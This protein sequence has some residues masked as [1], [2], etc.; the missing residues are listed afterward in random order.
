MNSNLVKNLEELI[1]KNL[2]ATII[3][4]VRGN[5]IRIGRYAIRQAKAGW[6]VVYDCETNKQDARLF[7]KTAAVAY[8]KTKTQRNKVKL[9]DHTIQKHYNDCLFYKYT[10]KKTK[11][12]VKKEIIETRYDISYIETKQAKQSL[13]AIIFGSQDK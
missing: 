12:P 13:D 10:M 8:V 7:C 11:D 5:S 4:Y 3:P 9:L 2:D 1:N 6:W